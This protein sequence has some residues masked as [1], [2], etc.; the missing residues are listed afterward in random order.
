MI[1]RKAILL[2]GLLLA[3]PA[4]AQTEVSGQPTGEGDPA[5]L[6]CRRPMRIP[7]QRLM[8]PRVCKTNAVWAQY[9]EDGME[10][11]A[12]GTRDIPA[13][14]AQACRTQSGGS[15]GGGGSSARGLGGS[16]VCE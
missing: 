6:V 3:S 7:G 11:S 14:N 15:G 16:I 4:L 5:E 1:L 2:C 12:D 8:G 9:R 10:V 13:K